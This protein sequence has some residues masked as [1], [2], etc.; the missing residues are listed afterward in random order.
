MQSP[1]KLFAMLLVMVSGP[2]SAEFM[3]Y[4]VENVGKPYTPVEGLC[5]YQEARGFSMKLDPIEAAIIGAFDQMK[6][7][8]AEIGA[9]ALVA[10]DIDFAN[11]T[12]KDEGRVVPCGTL[13]KF[14]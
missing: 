13:V 4:T 12:Q 8:A 2:A 3:A 1:L 7:R 11:R 14:D 9:D 6:A 5:V 10:F